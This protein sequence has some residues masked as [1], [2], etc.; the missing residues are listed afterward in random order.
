MH[1]CLCDY[2]F[3]RGVSKTFQKRYAAKGNGSR[4]GVGILVRIIV[5]DVVVIVGMGHR[6][7]RKS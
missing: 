7:V 3:G 5:V 6:L 4:V 2:I 1:G